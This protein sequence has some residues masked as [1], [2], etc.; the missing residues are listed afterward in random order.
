MTY[1]RLKTV[2]EFKQVMEDYGRDWKPYLWQAFKEDTCYI[3]LENCFISLDRAIK[4]GYLE[5]L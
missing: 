1:I 5:Q 3:P 2:E 4:L